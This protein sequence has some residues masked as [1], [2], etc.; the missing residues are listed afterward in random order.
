MAGVMRGWGLAAAVG[1][2]VV[3]TSGVMAKDR[4]GYLAAAGWS[5]G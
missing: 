4:Q 5:R 2:M 1:L 3:S